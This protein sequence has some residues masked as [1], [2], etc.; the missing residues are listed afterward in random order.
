MNEMLET[1]PDAAAAPAPAPA[2]R[3]LTPDAWAMIERVA[4]AMHQARFFG[5]VTSPAAAM[6]IMLTG[7]ELGL[8]PAASFRFVHVIDGRPALSPKG[9]LAVLR[10]SGLLD[11]LE[12]VEAPGA[13]TV[14]MRR[15]GGESFS[16]TWTLEDARRAGVIRP[17]GGWDRYPQNML[18]WRAIGYVA[19][20]LF[21]DVLGG[22]HRADEV[23]AAIDASG[24]V[25]R[26][27]GG[28]DANPERGASWPAG[29]GRSLWP[30]SPATTESTG[31]A[32]APPPGET[33]ATPGAPDAGEPE[34]LDGPDGLDELV[35]RFGAEALLRAAGGTV[36]ETEAELAT[37]A[38]RLRAAP[39]PDAPVAEPEEVTG[40][41]A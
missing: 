13:C 4:P 41:A 7:Y 12:I 8:P 2:S 10:R 27:P 23:G 34:G 35:E 30:T 25:V 5:G 37:A 9:A 39:L 11:R 15:R 36:P 19:D 33:P 26:Q 17:N 3:P 29:P 1:T 16:L 32:A 21:P 28:S 31:P 14:A 38:D 6:A 40:G 24:D 18:R 22:L 20:V